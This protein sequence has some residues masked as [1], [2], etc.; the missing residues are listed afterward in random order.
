MPHIL[1]VSMTSDE[2]NVWHVQM[3]LFYEYNLASNILD[4]QIALFSFLFPFVFT[5]THPEINKKFR[6][7]IRQ[8][9]KAEDSPNLKTTIGAKNLILPSQEEAHT[10]FEQLK[11]QWN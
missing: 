3:S 9:V 10:Y 4:I 11:N 6:F 5:I 8:K 2:G 1:S 7:Y